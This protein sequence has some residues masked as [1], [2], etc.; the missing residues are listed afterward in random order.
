MQIIKSILIFLT[1]MG[2]IV[3]G[4]GL[5]FKVIDYVLHSTYAHIAFPAMIAI[6]IIYAAAT[7]YF[8]FFHKEKKEIKITLKKGST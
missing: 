8:C 5:M 4:I 6:F 2:L 7:I 1:I 3:I